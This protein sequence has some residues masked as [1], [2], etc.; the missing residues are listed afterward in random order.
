MGSN[1]STCSI[2]GIGRAP[3]FVKVLEEARSLARVPR[4]LMI[5]GERGTGKELLAHYI[6]DQSDRSQRPYLI[7]NCGAFQDELLV[8]HLFGHEK[9]AFTGAERPRVGLFEQAHG[10]TLFLDEIAN[11]SLGA[12]AKLHRAVEYKT[13]RR[14]GGNKQVKVDVRIIAATNAKMSKLIAGGKFMADL[15]DRLSFATLKL[16]PLRR[17]KKDIPLLIDYFIERLH[18]EMPDL[19]HAEFTQAAVETLC[20]YRWPGNIRELKNVVERVYVSDRDREI[21]AN[22]LPVEVTAT[23]PIGSSFKEKMSSFAKG[24]LLGALREAGGNQH[25]AA[26]ELGMTYDQFRHYY[27]KYKLGD[28]LP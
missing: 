9:G 8:S 18:D 1:A 6:H 23:Q 17:R 21:H 26:R 10:G 7:V 2:A 24:L 25:A 27:R 15:Y 5:L 11:I 19:G 14:V 3:S 12:Q 13:F 16:P 20:S 22:E 28:F 4:P